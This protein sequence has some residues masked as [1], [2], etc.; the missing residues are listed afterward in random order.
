M[1]RRPRR[2]LTIPEAPPALD[3]AGDA[4]ARLVQEIFSPEL[5]AE[6]GVAVDEV[7]LTVRPESVV[8]VCSVCKSDPRLDFDY[9]RCLSVVD[10]MEAS[11]ELEVNYHLYSYSLRHKMV[12]KAR[13]PGGPA[14]CAD[15]DRR[16]GRRGLAR[17]G[18]SRPVWGE[19]RGSSQ[20]HSAALV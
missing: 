14:H 16:L 2:V 3:A 15:G 5:D 13:V 18:V 4:L 7:T 17:A 8:P 12:V 10:Y 6:V 19:V 1:T 20:S 11:G 9:L